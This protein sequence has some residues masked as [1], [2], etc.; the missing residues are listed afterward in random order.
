MP[1]LLLALVLLA[2]LSACATNR[3]TAT[4]AE[5]TAVRHVETAPPFVALL[6]MV[7]S[8]SDFGEHSALV[9]NGSQMVIYDPAGS[10]EEGRVGLV[11]A[12][13]VLYGVTPDLVGYY[14]SYH[15]RHGY[16][17]RM[18]QVNI[19]PEEADALIAGVQARGAVSQLQCGTAVSDVLNDL[20]RFSTIR[21]TILPGGIMRRMAQIEGVESTD[22]VESDSGQNYR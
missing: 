18:Q 4:Q 3:T 21:T 8:K 1:K 20:P 15:A 11:R 7:N 6:T 16:Y 13:D 12:E 17:V 9:I 22:I 2:G 5:I 14:N 19:S 10:F